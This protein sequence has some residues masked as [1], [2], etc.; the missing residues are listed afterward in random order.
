MENGIVEEEK[1]NE[2]EEE[3]GI[4]EEEKENEEEGEEKIVKRDNQLQ[5]AVDLIKSW[6]IFKGSSPFQQEEG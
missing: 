2:E 4:V 1:E 3:N 6:I 5:R